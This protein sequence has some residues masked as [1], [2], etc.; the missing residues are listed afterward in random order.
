[1]VLNFLKIILFLLLNIF[2]GISLFLIIILVSFWDFINDQVYSYFYSRFEREYLREEEKIVGLYFSIHTFEKMQRRYLKEFYFLER[3]F[4][5]NGVRYLIITD[6][7]LNLLDKD[8][9]ILIVND[10]RYIPISTI[11]KIQEYSQ[12]GKVIFTYQSLMY[13]QFKHKYSSELL[14][15][16]GLYD[17]KF[18]NRRYQGFSY[19]HFTKVIL[20]RGYC[21]EYYTNSS[22]VLGWTFEKTPFLVKHQNYYFIAENT[23]CIE[24]L[25]NPIIY[26]F[27]VYLL[28]S[29]VDDLIDL[30]RSEKSFEFLFKDIEFIFPIEFILK[31]PKV[32]RHF[33]TSKSMKKILEQLEKLYL[34]RVSKLRNF[35]NKKLT[36]GLTK[37]YLKDFNYTNLIEYDDV[38][39]Y[40]L[41]KRNRQGGIEDYYSYRIKSI[42]SYNPLVV[43]VGIEDYICS[44][45]LSEMPDDFEL[46]AL[47]AQA[48]AA[49]TYAIK[50]RRRHKDYDLCD[51]PH[52]QNFE[53][54][55]QETF[56]SYIS[57]FSTSGQIIVN[58][59]QPIDAVYHSTCG[60]IT[61]NS[62]DVWSSKIQYLRSIKDY[63]KDMENAYCSQSPLF[64]WKIEIHR[65]KLQKILSTTVPYILNQPFEGK[66]KNITFQKN[67]SGRIQKLIIQTTKRT[68]VAFKE[69]SIYLFSEDLYFSLLPSSFV[70]RIEFSGDRVIFY[71]RGFGHGVG[72]CQFGANTLA[73]KQYTYIQI[74]QHYYSNVKIKQIYEGFEF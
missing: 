53:G 31:N 57:T 45:V 3:F 32:R 59:N 5:L 73:K 6:N 66:I 15:N 40:L 58:K 63:E 37:I 17:I 10:A 49:R 27:N 28:N 74:I 11:L 69:D 65:N 8:I 47:K 44:V 16:F 61:A 55:K 7:S 64:K 51:K 29:I 22:N 34:S 38:K 30:K 19:R 56:K 50:K 70:E 71:G 2:R 26:K 9:D 25:A 36:I 35:P 18:V 60:G 4:Y 23:F 1:M 14:S 72:M 62:E 52:C 13:N 46:E 54:E 20:S 67:S 48:L 33:Y 42:V 41:M 39:F 21:V 24:N 43:V 68:Y 12:Y